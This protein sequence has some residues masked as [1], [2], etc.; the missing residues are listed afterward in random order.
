[1]Q[2]QIEKDPESKV[3]VKEGV[4]YIPKTKE[5]HGVVWV[6]GEDRASWHVNFGNSQ[7]FI[8]GRYT[9][10]AGEIRGRGVAMQALPDAK[11][12][13]KVKEFV[14]Q[15]SAIDLAGMWT[16]T[17]DGVINPYSITVAPGIVIPVGSNNS[18]NPSLQRL[19]TGTNLSLAQFE[20]NDLQMAIKRA[21]FNDLRDPNGA[22]RSATEVAIEA[23]EIAKRIGSAYGR[24]QTEVL[25]PILKRV[26]FILKKKGLI[27]PI[28]IDGAEVEVKFTSPLA[29]AQDMD[30][31]MA[32]QQA[33]EFTLATAGEER[34]QMC[35][36]TEDFGTYAAK[37][38]GM[39]AELVR[40]PEEK[41]EVIKAG[42]EAKRQGLMEEN[43][44]ARQQQPLRSVT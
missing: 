19:D 29:T 2:N 34:A 1:M 35:F 12:L 6:K 31:L 21:L 10:V 30:D 20:I 33:F 32:V 3:D 8:T 41:A 27:K 5:Y 38:T 40:T 25:I 13:N 4:V 9:K 44:V 23:R 15:K 24:L 42:A 14:L 37:K 28:E 36:R 26:N 11:S 7:P 22:V 18:A 17:D 16:A 39:A 43:P